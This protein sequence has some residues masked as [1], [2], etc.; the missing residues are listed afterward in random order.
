MNMCVDF[1][2]SWQAIIL[3]MASDISARV[4]SVF[5]HDATE[6]VCENHVRDV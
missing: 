4:R 3:F 2:R 5:F 1:F 6:L